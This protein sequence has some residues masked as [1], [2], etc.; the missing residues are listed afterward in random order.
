MTRCPPLN[1]LLGRVEKRGVTPTNPALSGVR[2]DD[3]LV[4]LGPFN[5][6]RLG[7][8]A[9][10]RVWRRDH[11]PGRLGQSSIREEVARIASSDA[12]GVGVTGVG[13]GE[14]FLTVG[15]EA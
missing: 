1:V 11:S 4:D 3:T 7:G 14:E 13:A 12:P 15:L 10:G 5:L 9:S 6:D 2:L 8:L